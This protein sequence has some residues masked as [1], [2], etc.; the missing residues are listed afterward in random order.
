MRQS[1]RR[2]GVYHWKLRTRTSFLQR[3]LYTEGEE[4]ACLSTRRR[5]SK[6]RVH[7][8]CRDRQDE[9]VQI[10]HNNDLVSFQLHLIINF[11]LTEWKLAHGLVK[12]P[13]RSISH[14]AMNS[15]MTKTASTTKVNSAK[16]HFQ[17]SAKLSS[18]QNFRPYG[19]TLWQQSSLLGRQYRDVTAHIMF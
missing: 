19:I 15:I 4:F 3:V 16:W 12:F 6:R 10:K 18:C 5:R 9:T 2:Q 11:V 1:N 17:Q 7:G 14:F 8:R 13:V